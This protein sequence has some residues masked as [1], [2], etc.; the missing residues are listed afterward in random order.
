MANSRATTFSLARRRWRLFLANRKAVI[1]AIF[2]I[3]LSV[4][5]LTA[6][7]WSNSRPL[8]LSYGGELYFP[9]FKHYAPERFGLH[10]RLRVDYKAL[11][12]GAS[13]WALWPLNR[14]D[15]YRTNKTAAEYP[16]PPSRDNWFGT[17]DRGRDVFARL[18]YGFR[19]SLVFAIA[20]WLLSSL[21]ALVYGGVSG[22][23][24]SWVDLLSQRVTEILSTIPQLLLLI[25]LISLFEPSLGLLVAI[26]CG[27]G[28]IGL[29]YF[30]RGE[31]LR[32]RGLEYVEA[33]RALGATSK[34]ILLRCLLPNCL[35]PLLTFAPFMIVA[36]ITGLAGLDFMGFGLPAPTPSWG[37]LLNQAQTY[38]TWA[39]WLAFFPAFV[40][41]LTLLSL[42]LF[43]EGVRAAL[44]PN[45][46]LAGASAP[47]EQIPA[48][49]LVVLPGARKVPAPVA[50]KM[51]VSSAKAGWLL[52]VVTAAAAF[53]AQPAHAVESLGQL[54]A[55]ALQQTATDPML[56]RTSRVMFKGKPN[57]RGINGLYANAEMVDGKANY[58]RFEGVKGSLATGFQVGRMTSLT[59]GAGVHRLQDTFPPDTS[60]QNEVNQASTEAVKSGA[61]SPDLRQSA[62]AVVNANT[63]P[64]Y[65]ANL[66]TS[67][68]PNVW[69]WS[70][71]FSHDYVYQEWAQ[72]AAACH[73]LS[74]DKFYSQLEY[75]LAPR[76]RARLSG[77]A[78]PLSDGNSQYVNDHGVM[79]NLIDSKHMVLLGPG[80]WSTAFREQRGDKYWSPYQYSDYQLRIETH[81]RWT[82]KFSTIFK[83][84]LGYGG[85]LHQEQGPDTYLES[86]IQYAAKTWY[87]AVVWSRIRSLRSDNYQ[88]DD[89]GLNLSAEL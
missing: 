71:T 77:S 79:Y 27:F 28:W 15:P 70:T 84:N 74:S 35:L 4:F 61:I 39:W 82:Q 38:F 19:Y 88:R 33:E 45:A 49:E 41:F 56:I 36:N 2:V 18:L 47:D 65:T 40:L 55:E 1:A 5:S 54:K 86:R 78:A 46:P 8:V 26:S 62:A 85:E 23:V 48:R 81:L 60:K 37:E 67:T 32:T 20:V 64:Y 11:N 44:D 72:P 83:T 69:S 80:V 42:S 21:M 7:V 3:G 10:D 68:N 63:I 57:I 12:L 22:Y 16:A 53:T 6:E 58:V 17:D 30:V 87:A 9:V 59:V 29:S 75:Q 52:A 51:R 24:G 34:R 13:D 50:R 66:W 14:W 73:F 89:V 25:F 76:W 31:V 43:G